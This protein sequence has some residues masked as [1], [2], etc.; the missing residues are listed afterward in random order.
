MYNSRYKF[1][2]LAVLFY[3]QKHSVRFRALLHHV[4]CFYCKSSLYES[5][6][7]WTFLCYYIISYFFGWMVWEIWFCLEMSLLLKT[8]HVCQFVGCFKNRIPQN[9]NFVWIPKLYL[10]LGRCLW[11]IYLLS[12]LLCLQY[13]KNTKSVAAVLSGSS[14]AVFA[15][16]WFEHRITSCIAYEWYLE[17][18]YWVHCI[19]QVVVLRNMPSTFSSSSEASE[20][21]D[22][23]LLF[24][25]VIFIT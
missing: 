20:C 5:C 4:R 18:L 22:G 11:S 21:S 2:K 7:E 1:W 13:T 25:L 12:S 10:V 17:Y 8:E 19:K 23:L 14:G 6:R 24:W 15:G 9:L 3:C 16:C